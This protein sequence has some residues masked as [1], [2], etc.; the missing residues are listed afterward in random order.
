MPDDVALPDSNT[1]LNQLQ[2]LCPKACLLKS[3]FHSSTNSDE[4]PP[5]TVTPPMEKL[6]SFVQSHKCIV[7]TCSCATIFLFYHLPYTPE[8]TTDIEQITKGQS[9]NK[10]WHLLRKGLL[11]ASNFHQ[12]CISTNGEKTAESLIKPGLNESCLPLAVSFGRKYESKARA[13]FMKG[14]RFKHR[15]CSVDVPGLVL[16]QDSSFPGIACSPDG[17]VNCS[18]CGKFLVEIKCS[19]KYK[20]YYPKNALKLSGI[21]IEK[22]GEYIVKPTHKYY[23]QIQGQ[24][25][26]TGIDKCYLVLYTHKGIATVTVEFDEEFWFSVRNKLLSFYRDFYFPVLKQSALLPAVDVDR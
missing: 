21:C 4:T 26:L 6:K 10:N 25:A 23:F 2:L 8:E 11:T 5:L 14:H 20:C 22:D 9:Q 16:Y 13:M 1:F 12:I 24:M 7:D 15:H 18:L 17:I 19:F 3:V